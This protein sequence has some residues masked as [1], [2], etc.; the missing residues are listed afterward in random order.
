MRIMHNGHDGH[1]FRETSPGR[2]EPSNYVRRD[3]RGKERHG[4]SVTAIAE[5]ARRKPCAAEGTRDVSGLP[6]GPLTEWLRTHVARPQ[7]PR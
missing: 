7:D 3:C 5:P 2:F 6:S 1:A 4:G